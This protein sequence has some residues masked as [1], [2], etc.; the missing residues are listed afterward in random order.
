MEGT[1]VKEIITGIKEFSKYSIHV[2]SIIGIVYFSPIDFALFPIPKEHQFWVKIIIIVCFIYTGGTIIEK[3]SNYFK[4]WILKNQDQKA[5]KESL[6]S[7]DRSEKDVLCNFYH[8]GRNTL[9]F[10]SRSPIILGLV[11]KNVIIK[12]SNVTGGDQPY[13]INPYLKTIIDPD[14]HL[15][16]GFYK[17]ML[18][19]NQRWS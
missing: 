16:I 17:G 15:D 7:L 4:K 8:I 10:D 19:T 9:P 12:T 13:K 18:I 1:F 2:I 11:D 14:K 3:I 5:L 6:L